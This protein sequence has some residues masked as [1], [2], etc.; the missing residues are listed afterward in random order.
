MEVSQSDMIST[1]VYNFYKQCR[2]SKNAY[3]K[4]EDVKEDLLPEGI[5]L[6]EEDKAPIFEIKS[7]RSS[8]ME[9]PPA[10]SSSSDDSPEE[11]EDY[12]INRD[13]NNYRRKRSRSTPAP[14]NDYPIVPAGPAEAP[15]VLT[16]SPRSVRLCEFCNTS[17]TP[18]WRRGP[19]GKGT[20]CNACGV[21][22]SLSNRKRN[23]K[24]DS[25]PL[26][27]SQGSSRKVSPERNSGEQK[28]TGKARRANRPNKADGKSRDDDFT[29]S[30]EEEYKE[31]PNN[32]NN[33]MGNINNNNNSDKEYYCGYCN[34]TWP[35]GHF[36]NIQ[37]FGAHC[38]NCSRKHAK[39]GQVTEE[40]GQKRKFE[41]DSRAVPLPAA[42]NNNTDDFSGDLGSLITAVEDQILADE[43]A[44]KSVDS[45][46]D[47]MA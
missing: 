9:Q 42:T 21:K 32:S 16:S 14:F 33:S 39:E 18:M 13:L 37:Q 5:E 23:T 1:S 11:D 26:P 29:E 20:L 34:T 12:Q 15:A 4:E 47:I 7:T 22:W 2:L 17:D 46:A 27:G 28:T 45:K 44:K 43:A 40:T 36:K 25:N 8:T 24:R 30:S 31:E 10:E 38:S 41:E 19:S 3:M 35:Q 6:M